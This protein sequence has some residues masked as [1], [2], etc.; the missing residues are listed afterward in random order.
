[1]G[2][3]LKKKAETGMFRNGF[4]FWLFLF[5]SHTFGDINKHSGGTKTLIEC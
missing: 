2:L 1:M 5:C 3:G 4:F